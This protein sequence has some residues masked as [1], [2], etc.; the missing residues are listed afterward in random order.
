M[1]YLFRHPDFQGRSLVLRVSGFFGATK[2]V[3]DGAEVV[4]HRGKFTLHDNQ[5]RSHKLRLKP[6]FLDPIP[7]VVLD[8]TVITL[9]PPPRWYEYAWMSLPILL[10][11]YGGALGAI[12]G[13]AA[14]YSSTRIFRG[15]RSAGAKYLLS[16]A[17]SLGAV[18]VF[19]A[20]ATALQLLI[21]RNMDPSSKEALDAVAR[22]SNRELPMT[23]DDQTE[24]VELEALEGVLVYRFRLTKILPGQISGETLV[25]QLRP[26]VA[27]SACGN[28]ESRKRFLD[29]GVTLRYV[30]TDAHRGA[31]AQF[32]VSSEDCI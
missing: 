5:G 14:A 27:V 31:I 17:L 22:A 12:L 3:V 29:N 6:R 19:L 8:D 24:L 25:Q 26:V 20:G 11:F 21:L 10:V 4:G 23:I 13:L 32:D 1:D 9:V 2:L 28:G 30:Y 15:D 16:G 7:N 18:V